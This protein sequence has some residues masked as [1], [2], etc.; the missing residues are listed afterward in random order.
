MLP[1]TTNVGSTPCLPRTD[2]LAGGHTS[3]SWH[4]DELYVSSPA[5]HGK[6][7]A[8]TDS[9]R[10]WTEGDPFLSSEAKILTTARLDQTSGPLANL[11]CSD[12]PRVCATQCTA[13]SVL[14]PR[15]SSRSA[16]CQSNRHS[17]SHV[18]ATRSRGSAKRH[19]RNGPTYSLRC[20][21]CGPAARPSQAPA[22]AGP[23]MDAVQPLEPNPARTPFGQEQTL[24]AARPRGKIP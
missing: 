2:G 3:V 8:V 1:P 22:A 15:R 17:Q 4:A 18:P 9:F 24:T 7:L 10:K 16:K 14:A 23:Q 20:V 11:R 12:T 21:G 6:E 5:N 13:A 19:R